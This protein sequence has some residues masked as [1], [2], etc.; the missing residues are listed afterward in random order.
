MQMYY[1]FYEFFCPWSFRTLVVLLWVRSIL[2]RTCTCVARPP[3]VW[4]LHCRAV[5]GSNSV[6]PYEYKM[7]KDVNITSH[8]VYVL[9]ISAVCILPS[10]WQGSASETFPL[11]GHHSV[12]WHPTRCWWLRLSRLWWPL[13]VRK[14]RHW[15]LRSFWCVLFQVVCLFPLRLLLEDWAVFFVFF[16]WVIFASYLY[17]HFVFYHFIIR[18]LLNNWN[19]F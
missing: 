16:W 18:C 12:I 5:S 10:G 19:L 11:K 9:T 15:S 4:K 3:K 6:C 2:C 17:S 13:A 1:S 7:S 14:L 8:S